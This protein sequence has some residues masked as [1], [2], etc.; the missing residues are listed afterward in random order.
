MSVS[1]TISNL[2]DETFRRLQIEAQRRGV[3]LESAARSVLAS[4]LPAV[5][6][7]PR[8]ATNG[9]P[10]HD[11]DFL[12]GTWSEDEAQSFLDAVSQFRPIDRDVWQ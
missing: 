9:P 12:V 4:N 2:D 3:D 6:Q 8:G 7:T 11:L 1:F 10:Y 5:E